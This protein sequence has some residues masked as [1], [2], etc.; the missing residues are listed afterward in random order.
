M[1]RVDAL[2]GLL[3]RIGNFDPSAFQSNFND[4]LILQKTIYLMQKSN[5]FIGYH[6]NYYLRG[7]YSP[8]LT[9]DTYEL[10]NRFDRIPLVQF[11]DSEDEERFK[12]F[13]SFIKP[14]LKDHTW[15]EKIASILFL[16]KAYPSKSKDEIY[17]ET[18]DKIR[19]LTR[20]EFD[21][22]CRELKKSRLL[23]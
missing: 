16:L 4:R 23:E 5:L 19:S 11:D 18:K 13:L 21:D 15:L 6:Y 9:R 8:A 1:N 2:G 17:L 7:P 22:I 12:L 20:S 3:K 14:H 10:L